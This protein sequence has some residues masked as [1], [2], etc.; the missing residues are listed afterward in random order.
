MDNREAVIESDADEQVIE[1]IQAGDDG[2]LDQPGSD[3]GDWWSDLGQDW[4][5]IW[6]WEVSNWEELRMTP[7]F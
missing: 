3:K 5:L 2:G 7:E 1:V 6:L 4:L